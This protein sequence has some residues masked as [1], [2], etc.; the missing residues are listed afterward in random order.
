MSLK[1]LQTLKNNNNK[2]ILSTILYN[3]FDSLDEMGKIFKSHK[4][5]SKQ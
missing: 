3:K 1:I 4:D 2:R 5:H